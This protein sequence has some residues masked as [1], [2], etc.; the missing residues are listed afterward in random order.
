MITISTQ[1]AEQIARNINAMDMNYEYSDDMRKWRF[2]NNL[3]SKLKKILSELSD[4]DKGFIHTLC[5]SDKAQYFGLV[6]PV[7]IEETPNSKESF[8]TKVFKRAY[9]IMQRTGKSFAFCLSKAW[10]LHRLTQQLRTN[11]EVTFSYEK[12]DGSLR[13]AIGTLQNVDNLIK[14][15]G[16]S[17]INTIKY[18]DLQASA[19]RSFRIE[20]LV[21]VY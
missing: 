12:K 10:A 9:E 6:A 15:T 20:N 5:E 1:R 7:E 14:G 17:P 11:D 4:D 8:R 3:K 13:H 16:A 2:W 18:F 21:T 19:F